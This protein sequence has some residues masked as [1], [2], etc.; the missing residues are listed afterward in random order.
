MPEARE[1]QG[2]VSTIIPVF[3]RGPLLREAV[4]SVLQQD[5]RPIEILIVDDGST[6]ETPAFITELQAANP[7]IVRTLRVTNGGPGLAREA[8]R[9]QSRGEF[10]QYLDSDDVLLPGKFTAQVAALQHN[11]KAGAAYGITW[12]RDAKGHCNQQPHKRTGERLP[13]MF[14][15]MLNSRWWDTSTPL[16]R[17][18][19]LDRVGPW[20]ALR[21]EEDWEYDCRVARHGGTLVYVPMP[22]SQTRDHS[23]NR[24][25]RGNARDPARMQQRARAHENVTL[26]A[27]AAVLPELTPAL[28][29]FSR[30]LFLLCRQC[31]AAGLPG[32]SNRL[33]DLARQVAGPQR[34]ASLDFRLYSLIARILGWTVAGRVAEFLDQYRQRPNRA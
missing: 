13:H 16:Y 21:L 15:A 32:E 5:Y 2:L 23:L 18:G 6:D 19:V 17:R 27:M 1:I 9:L 4:A 22:V 34:A 20:S 25:S 12:Y 31:G 33:F 29:E 10:I 14:P 30:S 7:D 3:N 24:L 11:P 26:Q 8:G 28:A